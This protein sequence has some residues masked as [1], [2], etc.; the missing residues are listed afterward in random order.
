MVE[1]RIC[2][3]VTELC[4]GKGYLEVLLCHTARIIALVMNDPA[5]LVGVPNGPTYR[6][7]ENTGLSMT[8][9]W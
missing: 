8:G 1:M 6:E 2:V 5:P 3:A 9:P 7:L 4:H